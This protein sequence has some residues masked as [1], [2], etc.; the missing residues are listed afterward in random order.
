[1][2]RGTGLAAPCGV[3]LVVAAAVASAAVAGVQDAGA[4]PRLVEAQA[5]S[6]EA[7][8]LRGEGKHEQAI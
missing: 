1:M 8:K 7:R 3:A 4:D 2:L 6:D 5:A